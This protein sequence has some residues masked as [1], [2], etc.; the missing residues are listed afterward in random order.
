[1]NIGDGFCVTVTVTLIVAGEGVITVK[2]DE[3][4]VG[5]FDVVIVERVDDGTA[6]DV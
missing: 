2:A 1:M 4:D 5:S 6:A 3:V